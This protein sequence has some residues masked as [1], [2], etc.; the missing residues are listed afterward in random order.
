MKQFFQHAP[1]C[2]AIVSHLTKCDSIATLKEED[3][4]STLTYIHDKANGTVAE[5]NAIGVKTFENDDT[6]DC[7]EF[8]EI[9]LSSI[10][11]SFFY[12][13]SKRLKLKIDYI[14]NGQPKIINF[15]K[16]EGSLDR[17]EWMALFQNFMIERSYFKHYK[18]AKAL[19]W[20][21][22]ENTNNCILQS[23]ADSPW[24]IIITEFIFHNPI[25][26]TRLNWYMVSSEW[27]EY[28]VTYR[29][30]KMLDKEN[31]DIKIGWRHFDS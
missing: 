3:R 24:N 26:K 27:H 4:L 22:C 2:E 17:D 23:T 30:K 28:Y 6:I 5:T 13:E 1:I 7:Y 10:I 20:A 31:Y 12:I 21:Y 25:I 8:S 18:M 29:I 9:S 16:L 15:G 19:F 14:L 11:P